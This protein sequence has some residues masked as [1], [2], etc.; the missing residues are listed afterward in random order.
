MFPTV[1]LPRLVHVLVLLQSTLTQ[2]TVLHTVAT[3]DSMQVETAVR[4]RHIPS[5]VEAR[6]P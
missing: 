5:G 1:L 2:M 3:L 6:K 4:L